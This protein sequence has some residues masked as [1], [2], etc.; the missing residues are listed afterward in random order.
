MKLTSGR[1]SKGT[2]EAGRAVK[3]GPQVSGQVLFHSWSFFGVSGPKSSSRC[4]CGEVANDVKQV[5]WQ[6][7]LPL[8]TGRCSSKAQSRICLRTCHGNQLQHLQDHYF[9]MSLI[10]WGV[11]RVCDSHR[12]CPWAHTC[13]F[14]PYIKREVRCAESFKACQAQEGVVVPHWIALRSASN[15]LLPKEPESIRTPFL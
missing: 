6:E 13:Y 11:G 14:Y 4:R 3:L 2:R 7:W 9:A 5:S 1:E 10:F 12:Q 15:F 8:S